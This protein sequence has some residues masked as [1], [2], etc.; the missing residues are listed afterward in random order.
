ML[1]HNAGQYARNIGV[2]LTPGANNLSGAESK[3]YAEEVKRPLNKYLVDQGE[4]KV[5]SPGNIAS[6][7]PDKAV[8]LV[9]DTYD[10]GVLDQFTKDENVKRK[11]KK[12]LAAITAQIEAIKNPPKDKVVD[13]NEAQ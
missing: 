12:V 9:Q 13:P 3:L 11:D 2:R 7:T 4:I 10:L 6:I 5:I 8:Q 1:V